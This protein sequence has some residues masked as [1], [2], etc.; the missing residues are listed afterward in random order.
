MPELYK[1]NAMSRFF[2]YSNILTVLKIERAI[3]SKITYTATLTYSLCRMW[4]Q[5]DQTLQSNSNTKLK[6]QNTRLFILCSLYILYTDYQFVLHI[7]YISSLSGSLIFKT[8]MTDVQKKKKKNV[9][10]FPW[11]PLAYCKACVPGMWRQE[12]GE[13]VEYGVTSEAQ[14]CSDSFELAS[15]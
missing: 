11:A 6:C 12:N 7:S 9:P 13:L 5:N 8:V 10:T 3:L 15:P 1:C 14:W 4:Q 2:F